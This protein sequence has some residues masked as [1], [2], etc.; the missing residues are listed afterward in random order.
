V[1]A[2]RGDRAR[3]RLRGAE[4][5]EGSNGHRDGHMRGGNFCSFVDVEVVSWTRG[6]SKRP[7]DTHG[8]ASAP[9][10]RG[11]VHE[12]YIVNC[13]IHEINP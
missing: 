1:T 10:L 6:E 7:R 13:Y 2:R 3:V 4:R 5:S 11:Y 8:S 12:I 9:W